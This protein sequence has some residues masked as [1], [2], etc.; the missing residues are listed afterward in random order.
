MRQN[1][2]RNIGPCSPLYW[3]PLQI[4]VQ[5]SYSSSRYWWIA[6]FQPPNKTSN[7]PLWRDMRKTKNFTWRRYTQ[8]TLFVFYAYLYNSITLFMSIKKFLILFGWLAFH[9]FMLTVSLFTNKNLKSEAGIFSTAICVP[10]HYK[11]F[12]SL[13]LNFTSKQHLSMFTR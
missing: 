10:L 12:N 13:Q 3:K 7:C 1:Q 4:V 5:R 6:G 11:S 8:E 2:P 9:S